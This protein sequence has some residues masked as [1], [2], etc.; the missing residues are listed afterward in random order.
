VGLGAC[1]GKEVLRNADDA[2]R[3]ID[4]VVRGG[5]ASEYKLADDASRAAQA[6]YEDAG[7]LQSLQDAVDAAPGYACDVVGVVSDVGEVVPD[8]YEPALNA[9]NETEAEARSDTLGVPPTV[10][11]PILSAALDMAQSTWVE[12]ADVACNI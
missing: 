11:D 7:P 8:S 10:S 5:K 4:D 12:A 2:A 9:L 3:Y 6:A 1:G